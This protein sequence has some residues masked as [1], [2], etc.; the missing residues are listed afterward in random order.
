MPPKEARLMLK[1]KERARVRYGKGQGKCFRQRKQDP[2]SDPD[3]AF[4]CRLGPPHRV[5]RQAE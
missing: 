4:I 2:R 5:A 3:L 1:T